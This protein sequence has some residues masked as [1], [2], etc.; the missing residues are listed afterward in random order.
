MNCLQRRLTRSLNST[1]KL[2]PIIDISILNNDGNLKLRTRS[3]S[4][5]RIFVSK[6]VKFGLLVANK[7]KPFLGFIN[8]SPWKYL[9]GS[10]EK[11]VSV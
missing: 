5:S 8:R 7:I 10:T 4:M 3:K 6:D 2:A 1:R 11:S 9:L